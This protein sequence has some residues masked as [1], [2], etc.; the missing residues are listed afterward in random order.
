VLFR[1]NARNSDVP[2]L[3]IAV[4]GQGIVD[5]HVTAVGGLNPYKYVAFDFTA[6]GGSH[7]LMVTPVFAFSID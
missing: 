5:M 2:A 6:T 7:T 4:D 1:A 3:R